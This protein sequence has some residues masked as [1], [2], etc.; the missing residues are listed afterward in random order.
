MQRHHCQSPCQCQRQCHHQGHLGRRRRHWHHYHPLQPEPERPSNW[1]RHGVQRWTG[2]THRTQVQARFK[3]GSSR[4]QAA[5]QR[6]DRSGIELKFKFSNKGHRDTVT[7]Q[8]GGTTGARQGHDRG[9]TETDRGERG[10]GLGLGVHVKGTLSQRCKLAR[11]TETKMRGPGGCMPRPF[12]AN[13]AG[14][15]ARLVYPCTSAV[16]YALTTVLTGSQ[17]CDCSSHS[18]SPWAQLRL[19][20]HTC[21]PRPG[22]LTQPQPEG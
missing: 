22:Q 3:Q 1:F 16:R 11:E 6:G 5:E 21:H 14:A 13:G 9:T 19:E 18:L 20:A 10:L 17:N 15:S 4:V 7:E 2:L 12:S 8:Q